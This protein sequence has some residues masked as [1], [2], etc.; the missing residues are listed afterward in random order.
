MQAA[1]EGVVARSFFVNNSRVKLGSDVAVVQIRP[2]NLGCEAVFGAV[3]A[4]VAAREHHIW[5]GGQKYD[6]VQIGVVIRV[7]FKKWQGRAHFVAANFGRVIGRCKTIRAAPKV[8]SANHDR[9]CSRLYFYHQ[10]VAALGRTLVK[11]G[12]CAG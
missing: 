2:F 8:G 11:F 12:A 6:F 10:I 9:V 3:N 4:A 1:D 7:K 5:V